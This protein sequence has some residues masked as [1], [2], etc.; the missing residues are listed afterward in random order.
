MTVNT[1]DIE[2]EIEGKSFR[3]GTSGGRR[4]VPTVVDGDE[5][6]EQALDLAQRAISKL[7]THQGIKHK[8]DDEGDQMT[9]ADLLERNG[10]DASEIERERKLSEFDVEALAVGD[11]VEVE[12][13]HNGEPQ[14][15]KRGVVRDVDLANDMFGARAEVTWDGYMYSI[16]EGAADDEQRIT[17][18]DEARL[19]RGNSMGQIYDI[20]VVDPDDVDDEELLA[21]R[22]RAIDSAELDD[23][24]EELDVETEKE[25][26][27]SSGAEDEGTDLHAKVT[28]DGPG[29]DE[30][31]TVHCRNIFDA[32]WT[33]SVEADLDDET[34]RRVIRAARNNSP[35]PTGP[36]L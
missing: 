1:E 24:A 12:K 17:G 29:L 25:W 31:V 28:V 21:V 2:L 19:G 8:L 33:A 15:P 14:E 16:L 20:R 10:L 18:Y 13:L 6:A 27:R 34:E 36:R 30:P 7:R 9:L 11:I 3:T 35:I 4:L 22:E 5:E 32:G 23:E 26:E